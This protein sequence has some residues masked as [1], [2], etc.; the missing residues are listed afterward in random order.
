MNPAELLHAVTSTVNYLRISAGQDSASEWLS[1]GELV[2]DHDRLLTVVRSTAEGRGTDR[3]DIAMSLFLQAYAFRVASAAIG[4]WL[5]SEGT[6]TFDVRPSNTAIALGRHRPNALALHHV[7][8]RP[9]PIHDVLF[10][11]HLGPMVL[12]AR[13]TAAD[14]DGERVGEKLLWGNVAAGCASAFGAFHG[15]LEDRGAVRDAAT[16][17]FHDA[18]DEVRSAGQFATV[19]GQQPEP[20]WFWERNSCCLLYQLPTADTSVE[21]FKCE[22]CSLWS[23]EDRIIRYATATATINSSE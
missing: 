4:G 14:S 17:F 6:A 11:Q 2:H 9:E 21:P 1:C 16:R 19:Q 3:D 18:P 12:A 8:Y 15:N 22:D 23:A 7:K 13:A 20:G 10:E 5:L